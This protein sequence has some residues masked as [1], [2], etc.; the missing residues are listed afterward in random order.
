MDPLHMTKRKESGFG[1]AAS[2]LVKSY[3]DKLNSVDTSGVVR[4][5]LGMAFA[6]GIIMFPCPATG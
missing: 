5:A 3:T 2:A 1:A 6:T 4:Q